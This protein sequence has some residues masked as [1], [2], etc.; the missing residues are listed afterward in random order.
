[1]YLDCPENGIV[2]FQNAFVRLNEGD[3]VFTVDLREQLHVF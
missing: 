1:M 3:F 2:Y